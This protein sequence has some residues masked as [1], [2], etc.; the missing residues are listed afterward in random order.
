VISSGYNLWAN[1]HYTEQVTDLIEDMTSDMLGADY[2]NGFLPIP[3]TEPYIPE[4]PGYGGDEF[5]ADDDWDDDHNDEL[6]TDEKN[7]V[8]RVKA[9]ALDGFP[10]FSIEEVLLS[11]VDEDGLVWDY[12]DEDYEEGI[13][14]YV[15]AM[16]F[17]PATL[18]LVYA[19]FT[20]TADG[21]TLLT[22]LMIGDRDEYDQRAKE[23]YGDWYRD[24]LTFGGDARTA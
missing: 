6:T 16:G 14:G 19:D 12:Y 24:M 2:G 17:A 8:D 11:R 22:N 9:D 5:G 7:V 18:D 23:L 15:T 4:I 21:R 3:D 20:L 10:E 1:D 13:V